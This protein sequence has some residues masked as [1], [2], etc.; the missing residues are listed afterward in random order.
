MLVC[1][2]SVVAGGAAMVIK[3]KFSVSD[4]W[5]DI[6]YYKATA[7]GYVGEM[8]KYLLNAPVQLSEKNNTLVKMIG[9]GL[10][11]DIWKKFKERFG[12]EQIAEFYASSEGN[13]AFFNTFNI[14]GTMGFSVT[15]YAIVE[16]DTEQER[17]VYDKKGF[18]KKVASGGTGL[19]LGEISDRYPFDG[20]T[21]KSKTEKAIFRNVFEK[22]DAWFN[23]NDLVRDMGYLHTQFV[24]RLGDTFRWK[25]EN[26][27]TQ[28][29]E[30]IINQ[31]DGIAES[32]V[33][34]VEV[35]ENNGRAGMAVLVL[36]KPVKKLNWDKFHQFLCE[37]LPP[38]AIPLFI[39][40]SR[41]AQTTDTYKHKKHDLKM[42]SFDLD[43]T[44]DEIY[45]LLHKK[46]TRLTPQLKANLDSGKYRF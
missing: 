36:D 41:E 35:P 19:L 34:G 3:N 8:C 26:V 43:N 21:E 39:K 5:D 44:D 31:F 1:W 10:R 22:G 30:G 27:S 24:D 11:P 9:N 7:F 15:S 28:E 17:P 2:G 42:A 4:F 40:I 32:I 25:G 45:A 16:Y 33:F 20:Y 13:I 46:Y 12:I 18:M 14:D 37:E 29:V 23:T 6:A 38:Y